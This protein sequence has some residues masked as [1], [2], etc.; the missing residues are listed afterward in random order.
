MQ[1]LALCLYLQKTCSYIC[2]DWALI[3]AENLGPSCIMQALAELLYIS[4][5]HGP[6]LFYAC[7]GRALVS[8]DN[9]GPSCIIQAL[10]KLLYL[11]RTWAL[12]VL[13]RHWLSSYICREHKP[14][15]FYAGIGW[16][17]ISAENMGASCI[18]QALAE[19]LYL[20]RTGALHVSCR[21]WLTF[22][23]CREH[24]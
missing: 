5:E 19:L 20:Q 24:L 9:M 6:F 4:R 3:S 7:I 10:A 14:F 8:A 23:I 15:L 13:S 18:M 22:C 1:A 2:R 16:A 21:H 17:L 11:Q 12:P